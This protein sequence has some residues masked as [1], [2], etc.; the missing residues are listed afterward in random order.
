MVF[1]LLVKVHKNTQHIHISS[2]SKYTN[3][4]IPT[5]CLLPFAIPQ[6]LWTCISLSTAE[7]RLGTTTLDNNEP[8]RG[9]GKTVFSTSKQSTKN[10]QHLTVN[11]LE[12]AAK[13][14]W[15]T[16]GLLVSGIT[17]N[18]SRTGLILLELLQA[19]CLLFYFSRSQQAWRCR[20]VSRESTS[21]V[22]WA[23]L[24]LS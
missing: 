10:G 20:F 2:C 24:S 23:K 11:R 16:L 6:E 8:G 19:I 15:G 1:L 9:H 13:M 3:P 17:G 5:P 14:G 4:L 21:E 7:K 22:S 18:K 12:L